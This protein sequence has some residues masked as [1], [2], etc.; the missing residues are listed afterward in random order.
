MYLKTMQG[1]SFIKSPMCFEPMKCSALIH[2]VGVGVHLQVVFLH[3][4]NDIG[5]GPIHLVRRGGG[6][7]HWWLCVL[8]PI[9]SRGLRWWS[10]SRKHKEMFLLNKAGIALFIS[11]ALLQ[12][13]AHTDVFNY[14][15]FAAAPN[16]LSGGMCLSN[17]W[18]PTIN[19]FVS[20]L[21]TSRSKFHSMSGAF[22]DNNWHFKSA[23]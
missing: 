18:W 19:A 22:Q 17:N 11:R 15:R 13:H 21:S 1:L 16:R 5:L 4:I 6:W 23:I 8:Q 14:D 10:S 12:P 7:C 20:W 3:F 9:M 2:S